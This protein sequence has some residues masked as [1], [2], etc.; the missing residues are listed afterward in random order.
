[1]QPLEFGKINTIGGLIEVLKTFDP[2][3]TVLVNWERIHSIDYTPLGFSLND[4]THAL[5]GTLLP[6]PDKSGTP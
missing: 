5:T 3:L 2:G 1:M 6:L 4:Q